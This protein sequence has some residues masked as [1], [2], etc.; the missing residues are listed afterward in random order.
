MDEMEQVHAARRRRI[1][2]GIAAAAV[3]VLLFVIFGGGGAREIDVETALSRAPALALTQE[4]LALA[5]TILEPDLFRSALSYD[6][7][8]STTVFTTEESE[9]IIG[10]VIPPDA[11]V[12]EIA[13]TGAVVVIDYRQP[14]HR[15]ILEYVD[16]DRSGR[17]DSI[18]KSL[19]PII[20]GTATGCYGLHHDLLTGET[21]CT[22]LKY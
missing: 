1:L 12:T 9:A 2:I 7:A 6:L 14:Q 13:V 19:S 8:D 17:V 22:Y 15:I 16:A 20:D 3:M 21:T 5:E 4:E 11:Q 10:S 18:R